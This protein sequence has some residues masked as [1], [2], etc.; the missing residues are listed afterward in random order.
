MQ[1]TVPQRAQ[2]ALNQ[3]TSMAFR[4]DKSVS[5]LFEEQVERTPDA[6][7]IAFEEEEISYEELNQRVRR[8]AAALKKMGIGRDILVGLS[9]DRPAEM[10]IGM[11]SILKAGGAYLP[12]A[13][14]DPQDRL[15]RILKDSQATLVLTQEKLRALQV[16]TQ[17]GAVLAAN[18]TPSAQTEGSDSGS[19]SLACVTYAPG[20]SVLRGVQM[21]PRELLNVFNTL[22]RLLGP[23]PG[24][25]LASGKAWPQTAL[26]ELLWA[27][28]RGFKLV[29]PA[30]PTARSSNSKRAPAKGQLDFSLFYFGSDAAA[31]SGADK[32]RLLLEGAKF[33]DQHGFAAVWTPER[34]FHSIGG[35]YPNPSLS[36]AAI[37]VLTRN[38]QI[39]AGSVVL[40]LHNP[41]RVAEEWSVV[42]NLSKGRAAISL[43]SGWHAN[44]FALAPDN[45]SRRK[46]IMLEG[47]QTLRRLWQGETVA[48]ANGHGEPVKVRI[49]PEPVQ[50]ELPIWLTSS[51]NPETFQWA[52]ELGL[53]LLTHL[54]GQGLGDLEKKLEIYHAAWRKNGHGG[55][56]PLV[57]VM[58][59]TFV[60]QDR[61]AAWETV[62][63]PLCEY[64]RTFRELNKTARPAAGST[65]RPTAEE[66]PG[67]VEVLLR[68]A[69]ERYFESSGL[70]GPAE[71]CRPLLEKLRA[72][73]VNEL[74]CLIDFGI[75]DDTVLAGLEYL[76]QLRQIV[77]HKGKVSAQSES[78]QEPGE[79]FLCQE[80]R[81]H[82]VTHLQC[83]A[84][85]AGSLLEADESVRALLQSL[86]KVLL[87]GDP[88]AAA[89][90]QKL[91]ELLPGRV[92][93]LGEPM[94]GALTGAGT[95][96]QS[97]SKS[98]PAQRVYERARR[99]REVFTQI[100]R[101]R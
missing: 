42:D 85:E 70:F 11:L 61:A 23:G 20:P 81:R 59:H 28:S 83:N 93:E 7:A 95:S 22:D 37:A 77:N 47:I 31:G 88:V 72:L 6:V 26:I 52:G 87:S 30:E 43:A 21:T 98:I 68:K 56:E 35:I 50:H 94:G 49:F 33:A 3:P 45:Y 24:V 5:Q 65:A 54:F 14:A 46:E 53:N 4:G 76:E 32:Y 62:R 84:L 78:Q 48:V 71:N 55:R 91:A 79:N 39:R 100:A 44:D 51:G 17:N 64:L 12:L 19:P 40:P 82:K 58:M 16:E 36:S 15:D 25:W 67:D 86:D 38:I 27:L 60:W 2:L 96:P 99:Q 57:S 69:A 8:V 34:H 97:E 75:E 66:P 1:E 73:G 18:Q 80:I 74:A 13:P 101:E 63:G 41:L 9:A 29:F 90:S 10:L 92:L 89:V